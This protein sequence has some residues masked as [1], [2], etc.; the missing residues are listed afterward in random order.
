M[1][2]FWREGAIKLF[3]KSLETQLEQNFTITN[4]LFQ[5]NKM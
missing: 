3:E 5:N 1:N 4:L 2:A